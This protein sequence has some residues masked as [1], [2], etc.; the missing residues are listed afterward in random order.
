MRV[1]QVDVAIIGA[2]RC[3]ARYGV[4]EP[5]RTVSTGRWE[6][7]DRRHSMR[8]AVASGHRP[9][10]ST[11]LR[12][13]PI[14]SAERVQ[15]QLRS[16]RYPFCPYRPWHLPRPSFRS[17]QWH[18]LRRFRLFLQVP[19]TL[20]GVRQVRERVPPRRPERPQAQPPALVVHT[21]SMP[22]RTGLLQ[23]QRQLNIS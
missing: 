17:S 1:A 18:Q 19:P 9:G 14:I 5:T 10:R 3:A 8:P 2:A 4:G 16:C 6:S 23:L 12:C 20:L 13:N 11:L 21:R 7:V 15:E 22:A